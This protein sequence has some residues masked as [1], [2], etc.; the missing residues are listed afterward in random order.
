MGTLQFKRPKVTWRRLLLGTLGVGAVA[1]AVWLGRAV[2]V[3]K[4][5][6]APLPPAPPETP[7]ATTSA[8]APPVAAE[9]SD[10]S[11][12]MVAYVFGT[13]NVTREQLGEYLIARLGPDKVLNLVNRLIIERT[14][15]E[16]GV[17][18]TDAEV[19]VAL[20]EDIA[21]FQINR[22]EFVD[23]LLRE[24]HKSLYEWKED[25]LRPKLLMTKMLQNQV[26]IEEDDV[27]KAYESS[28]GEKVYCQAIIWPKEKYEEARKIYPTIRDNPEEFERQA[29]GQ[30][31]GL[32]AVHGMMEP[33][34]RFG[35][36]DEQ[37]EAEV[38]KLK[39]GEI[40]VL[41]HSPSNA[42]ETDPYSWVVMKLVRR[43]P[44][45][46]TK[47]L[48]D[49]RPGLEK[50]ILDNKV[51]AAIFE[52]MKVLQKAAAPKIALK[53]ILPDD[54]WDRKVDKVDA[55]PADGVPT[56]QQPVAFIYGTTPVTREQLGEYLIKRYGADR[57][58]L[59]VNKM[60]VDKACAEHGITVSEAEI[61]A[62]LAEDIKTANAG[63]KKQ[64]IQEYLRAN[65][66]NLYG[67]REDLLRPKLLL[68][69][70]AR[71]HVKVEEE[72]LRKAAEAYHGEKAE[73]QIIMWAR[74]PQDHEIAI[75][76]YDVIRKGKEEFDR[77]AKMQASPRLAA[78]A[79][80]IEP[81]SRHTTGNDDLEKEVFALREGEL[82]PLVETPQGY[83]VARL[84]RRIPAERPTDDPAQAAAE[85]AK[86]E[87]EIL[88][89]KSQKQ[90]PVEFAKLRTAAAPNILLQPML[91]E[92]DW[93]RDVKKEIGTPQ[94]ERVHGGVG[95]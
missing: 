67:Y 29:K 35:F 60:I 56:A 21:G 64:F 51:R 58:E 80:L 20:A 70:L 11:R 61:E 52:E 6:A 8:P 93:I 13:T 5:D 17:T 7:A 54:D 31:S 84:N 50:E 4:A 30:N 47:K 55:P 16:R 26:R 75:K 73:C 19:D 36:G 9:P 71:G 69:K 81:F 72:D 91:R 39:E 53:P 33:F 15:T 86:W 89:K 40:T 94:P 27:R 2:L 25:V 59:M 77:V 48:E 95:Q 49:V 22:R 63:T 74:T 23:K 76:Q 87:A 42:K 34:G 68:T 38:F 37:V 1:G 65:Q 12:R 66:T 3:T 85:R 10:Y 90:I 45:N 24:Y 78:K 41:L 46:T 79:G 92:E 18:V 14:C 82:T 43:L 88:E 32:A 57:I 44:A 83:V 62:A 28:Y